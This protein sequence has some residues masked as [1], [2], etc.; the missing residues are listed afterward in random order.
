MTSNKAEIKKLLNYW[1]YFIKGIDCEPG[2]TSIIVRWWN[3]LHIAIGIGLALYVPIQMNAAA[4]VVLFPLIGI[5]I[6]LAFAW[7]GNSQALLQTKE[8]HELADYHEGGFVEYV[9][10]Y[11]NA[12]LLILVTLIIWGIAGLSF[13]DE[14]WPTP[15]RSKSYLVV[16]ATLYTFLCASVRECWRVV[17]DT[18]R[19]LIVQREIK[20]IEDEKKTKEQELSGGTDASE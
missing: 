14:V 15:E 11:Q 17:L 6:G 4:S 20:K 3:I 9:Y 18:Q 1:G 19:M 16:E 12:V 7:S 8:I 5:L 2:I 13:F 10:L